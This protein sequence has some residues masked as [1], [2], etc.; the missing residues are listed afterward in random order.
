MKMVFEKCIYQANQEITMNYQKRR[1]QYILEFHK[2]YNYKKRRHQ[3]TLEF[4]KKYK[5]SRY[6]KCQ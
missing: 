4:H 2:K 3:H 5:K 1:H 6:L